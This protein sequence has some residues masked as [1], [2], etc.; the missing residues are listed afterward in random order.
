MCPIPSGL[1]L[2]RYLQHYTLESKYGFVLITDIIFR[3]L[4]YPCLYVLQHEY[5]ENTMR[6]FYY[7]ASIHELG[8][9]IWC[10]HI[11]ILRKLHSLACIR[12]MS[13]QSCYKTEVIFVLTDF[14]SYKNLTKEWNNLLK[15]NLQNLV[16]AQWRY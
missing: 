6:Q 2:R 8:Q 11:F 12:K 10:S 1:G 14:L 15:V 16:L 3:L 9:Y 5:S 13:C 7:Y 4:Q